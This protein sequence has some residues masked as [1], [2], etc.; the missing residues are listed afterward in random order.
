MINFFRS[1][2][3]AVV[4]LRMNGHAWKC[5]ATNWYDKLTIHKISFSLKRDSCFCFNSDHSSSISIYLAWSQD[6]LNHFAPKVVSLLKAF[7][8]FIVAMFDLIFEIANSWVTDTF[9]VWLGW[10]RDKCFQRKFLWF[11]NAA[12]L[13]SSHRPESICKQEEESFPQITWKTNLKTEISVESV[14]L[15]CIIRAFI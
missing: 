13:I 6:S 2:T 1:S 4:N 15:V 7:Y 5:F 9:C 3:H 10:F 12:L 14:K 8:D 11:L